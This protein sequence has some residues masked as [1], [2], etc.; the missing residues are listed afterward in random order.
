MAENMTEDYNIIDEFKNAGALLEG[1]FILSSGRHSPVFLQKNAVMMYP[2]RAERAC[3][4]LA[5]KITDYYGK[6]DVVISPAVG[7]IIPGYETA[8]HLNARAIFV[9]RD[10]GVFQLRRGFTIEP[11]ERA[12]IVED[13]ITTGLSVRETLEALKIYKNNVLGCACLIDRSGGKSDIGHSLISL[14]EYVIPSYAVNDIPEEL[15]NIPAIKPGS[16]DLSAV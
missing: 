15:K 1:H 10:H 3:K 12:I 5:Q 6:I 2:K 8:R 11:H 9:E 13:I 14:A 7:G 4:A 16:R